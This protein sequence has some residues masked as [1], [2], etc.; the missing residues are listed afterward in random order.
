MSPTKL[1]ES[2]EDIIIQV[3]QEKVLWPRYEEGGN[4]TTVQQIIIEK[5]EKFGACTLNRNGL[6]EN[7]FW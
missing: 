4:L 6:N 2:T 3:E 5:F 7:S 1:S